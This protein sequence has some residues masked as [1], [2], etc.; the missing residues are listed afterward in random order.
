MLRRRVL[1]FLAV[2]IGM[3]GFLTGVS[4]SIAGAATCS[5][6]G[7]N[8]TL[9][10]ESN[11]PSGQVTIGT[12][13]TV[14]AYESAPVP[15]SFDFTGTV[16]SGDYL[17]LIEATGTAGLVVST[18]SNG[19]F[20]F[21]QTQPI[22][23]I[24]YEL[25]VTSS[26]VQIFGNV[27]T[28]GIS[29]LGYSNEI[30]I[31]WTYQNQY[32]LGTTVANP[33]NP[34]AIQGT[35]TTPTIVVLDAHHHN[36]VS[37]SFISTNDQ[38][39]S[40][41]IPGGAQLFAFGNSYNCFSSV[42]S[43]PPTTVGGCNQL[44]GNAANGGLEPQCT[45]APN[46]SC[47]LPYS[48]DMAYGISDNSAQT[49]A[50]PTNTVYIPDGSTCKN[51][52]VEAWVL[53]Y[54]G[55]Q[56]YALYCGAQYEII[57]YTPPAN[58]QAPT[59]PSPTQ[60][61]P[62]QPSP[63]GI[64][65]LSA[66]PINLSPGSS[67][68]LTAVTSNVPLTYEY[69]SVYLCQVG[70]SSSSRQLDVVNNEPTSAQT[71][72]SEST[73]V[74][75][76]FVAYIGV[77]YNN[78]SSSSGMEATSNEVQVTWSGSAPSACVLCEMSD[79]TIA[80]VGVPATAEVGTKMNQT[81]AASTCAE[82]INFN[83]S[84]DDINTC[85]G[86]SPGG[87]VWD[88][89]QTGNTST[90]SGYIPMS[91]GCGYDCSSVS[92]PASAAAKLQSESTN[93][94]P[95]YADASNWQ[96]QMDRPLKGSYIGY[97]APITLSSSG[98]GYSCV[99]VNECPPPDLPESTYTDSSFA[100]PGPFS[101]TAPAPT[102]VA[103]P[104][105]PQPGQQVTLTASDQVPPNFA[106]SIIDQGSGQRLAQCV[107]STCSVT[108]Q[109]PSTATSYTAEL[110]PPETGSSIT[111]VSSQNNFSP[112]IGN[113]STTSIPCSACT[114]NTQD[115]QEQ[116]LTTGAVLSAGAGF[117]RAPS[118]SVKEIS[119]SS[120]GSTVDLQVC[121]GTTGSTGCTAPYFVNELIDETQVSVGEES[122]SCL[123]NQYTCNLTFNNV[124]TSNP[125]II[126]AGSFQCLYG[127][128]SEP[129]AYSN[130]L[131]VG[132]AGSFPTGQTGTL[133]FWYKY[134][135]NHPKFPL[136]YLGGGSIN[137]LYS[138][139][140]NSVLIA[141]GM[142][143][144]SSGC[145]DGPGY[146]VDT[147]QPGGALELSLDAMESGNGTIVSPASMTAGWNFIAVSASPQGDTLYLNGQ[148]VGTAYM[149]SESVASPFDVPAG[150][151]PD[152]N[153]GLNNI[154]QLGYGDTA[155]FAQGF[156]Q[157]F[158]IPQ[159]LSSGQIATLESAGTVNG[160]AGWNTAV[161]GMV[162][163]TGN[164]WSFDQPQTYNVVSNTESGNAGELLGTYSD[165]L[166]GSAGAYSQLIM[167]APG[168]MPGLISSI[169]DATSP[170]LK[171]GQYISLQLQANPTSVIKGQSTTLTVTSSTSIS[172][173]CQI[174]ISAVPNNLNGDF[175]PGGSSSN[176]TAVSSG[177]NTWTASYTLN[178]LPTGSSQETVTFQGALV[179]D[180]TGV[181]QSNQVPV[182]WSAPAAKPS[183][184]YPT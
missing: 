95:G 23:A 87:L 1:R 70:G 88:T 183:T 96:V 17:S 105:N 107:A 173:G 30:Y 29:Y 44:S 48:Q 119:A 60:P 41:A 12:G 160:G 176:A 35:S 49:V 75:D 157:V 28:S 113:A 9:Q 141:A 10:L 137:K 31:D 25:A 150:S 139:S 145:F 138:I 72:W 4:S 114:S 34:P 38:T 177:S 167:G 56:W 39:A 74:T 92:V 94:L 122:Q 57:W 116:T 7:C 8:V 76:T 90:S 19:T 79:Q 104:P 132:P 135:P 171:L 172:T 123:Y 111:S 68:T 181:T 78:C 11:L 140:G 81:V 121:V 182:T 163:S 106:L 36:S 101:F 143:T 66:S 130:M 62:T 124:S 99:P 161:Q 32:Q 65:T 20:S 85:K 13:Q 6:L 5:N 61:S 152:Y 153:T 100:T 142:S 18:D 93:G 174:I 164:W 149:S 147:A 54:Y 110:L 47:S 64:I 22:G 136:M 82:E 156:A 42:T 59:Q 115:W 52:F 158:A 175:S 146:C 178:A 33:N 128:A 169:P 134:D 120:S 26:P 109:T 55:G 159:T 133:G 73:D 86:Y 151:V 108:V 80:D 67:T 51:F 144:L 16:P 50:C 127:C 27:T 166:L 118:I 170:P 154:I 14:T 148:P 21:T 184:N 58:G 43:S 103:Q 53:G 98:Y 77:P 162:N 69:W 155:S 83:D 180:N 2:I 129:A 97:T 45:A 89:S 126:Q 24:A 165:N 84:Q 179:C 71:A 37:L 112:G 15:I 168:P 63:T 131:Q 3:A 125:I 102:L 46:S 40:T 91:D 117:I